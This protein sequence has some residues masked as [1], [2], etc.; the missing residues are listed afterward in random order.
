[1][2][3]FMP[4][5]VSDLSWHDDPIVG[6]STCFYYSYIKILP[7]PRNGAMS[8]NLHMVKVETFFPAPSKNQLLNPKRPFFLR[9]LSIS[10]A[11]SRER[12]L[13][14]FFFS[15]AASW[16]RMLRRHQK[17]IQVCSHKNFR[18]AL[19]LLGT[20]KNAAVRLFS[21]PVVL[22]RHGV[23]P[24]DGIYGLPY[25]PLYKTQDKTAKEDAIG[26]WALPMDRNLYLQRA[27]NAT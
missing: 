26:S 20:V 7:S 5:E 16:F 27:A 23:S 6:I 22:R 1:M 21:R 14:R 4:F 18:A 3:K 10:W 11:V 9:R 24:R 19:F 17:S 2:T 15:D 12:C 8:R 25:L 13:F